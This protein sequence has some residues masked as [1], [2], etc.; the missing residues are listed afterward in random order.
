MCSKSFFLYLKKCWWEGKF[1]G[2]R[3]RKRSFMR[4]PFMRWWLRRTGSVSL[5]F[6]FDWKRRGQVIR[7]Q[8]KRRTKKKTK[9]YKKKKKKRKKE[10]IKKQ[11]NER[12]KQVKKNNTNRTTLSLQTGRVAHYETRWGT[13]RNSTTSGGCR[14]FPWS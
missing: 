14:H 8:K 10:K 9:M 4:R 5:R 13:P 3:T 2:D 11:G 12:N 6:I 7:I 1:L